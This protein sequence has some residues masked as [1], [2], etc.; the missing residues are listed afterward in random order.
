MPVSA[1]ETLMQIATPPRAVEPPA[2]KPG[3]NSFAPALEKAYTAEKPR[4]AAAPAN[5]EDELESTADAPADSEDAADERAEETAEVSDKAPAE[6]TEQT[7]ESDE[8]SPD[9]EVEISELA[10]TVVAAGEAQAAAAA[11][12]QAAATETLGESQAAGPAG[13]GAEGKE[14]EVAKTPSDADANADGADQTELA[15]QIRA[16]AEEEAEGD[17][18]AGKRQSKAKAAKAGEPDVTEVQVKTKP[19]LADGAA[20]ENTGHIAPKADAEK[21]EITELEAGSQTDSKEGESKSSR[22]ESVAQLKLP[23]IEQ[24]AEL[25][26]AI[27]RHMAAIEQT[28]TGAVEATSSNASA[29]EAVAAAPSQQRTAATLDRLAAA[30]M[31]RGDNASSAEGGPTIDRPRF[32]QRVEGALRAAQQRDGRVQVRLAPPELGSLR[33]E[34]SVQNGAM[35]AKLEAETP[36]ARTALLDN[37]PALRDRLAEQNIRVEKFDVDIRRDS[38]GSG[39]QGNLP[40]NT[41]DRQEQGSHRRQHHPAQ[42]QV[43][44]PTPRAARTAAPASDAGLDVRI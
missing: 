3:G 38:Q 20:V 31:R 33:I 44:T 30:S 13:E 8:E 43:K 26:A 22:S 40:D 10:S 19:A 42:P 29:T 37:L 32:L 17:P 6:E 18:K 34:L 12:Q 21:P 24:T 9:D 28:A 15:A 39:G 23:P 16:K 7:G 11:Q 27:E 2:P 4:E 36:A 5:E 25:T 1:I 41:G 35:T 14:Q